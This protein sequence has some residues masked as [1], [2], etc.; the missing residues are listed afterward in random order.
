MSSSVTTDPQGQLLNGHQSQKKTNYKWIALS[1][2]T[3][4]ILMVMINSSIFVEATFSVAF[5]YN[6]IICNLLL[7]SK[8]PKQAY[9]YQLII[10]LE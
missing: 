10:S 3:L 6:S 9:S 8:N 1:N 5:F 2:T 4:G 7:K